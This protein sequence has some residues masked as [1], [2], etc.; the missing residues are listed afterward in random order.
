[1]YPRVEIIVVNCVNDVYSGILTRFSTKILV[2][3]LVNG[4]LAGGRADVS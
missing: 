3:R 2:I 1:M 4:G